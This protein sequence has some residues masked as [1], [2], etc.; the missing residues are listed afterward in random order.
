MNMKNEKWKTDTSPLDPQGSSP[1]DRMYSKAYVRHLFHANELLALHI[2]SVH[3]LSFYLDLVREA[4]T[5]IEAGTFRAWKDRMVIQ[6]A[7]RV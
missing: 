7:Q 3:N 1:V 2:G 4:R 6:L 5:Q